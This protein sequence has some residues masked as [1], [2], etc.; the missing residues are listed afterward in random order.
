MNVENS[1]LLAV[2]R[3]LTI[4][5]KL[6]L[7]VTDED[8]SYIESRVEAEGLTFLTVSLPSLGKS[9]Y[10]SF[11]TGALGT[12]EGFKRVKGSPYPYFL[13]KAW[14]VLFDKEGNLR[15]H[16][17]NLDGIHNPVDSIHVE[18]R[19]RYSSA[20]A[21][22]SQLTLMFYKLKM[23]YSD[24][25]VKD[26]STSFIATEE[27]L[28][29]F[30]LEEAEQ[31]DFRL[32][33]VLTIARSIICRLLHRFDPMEISPAHGSGA[34]SCKMIPW[35]RYG[36][37]RYVPKLDA[38][39]DYGTWFYSGALGLV[40]NIDK[41]QASDVHQELSARVC[42]VPKDSRGPRLI[43]A[44]PREYMYIQQGL[45]AKLYQAIETYPMVRSM[46]SCI[47]QSRNRE[48]AQTGSLTGLFATIDLKD[49]SDRVSLELVR[50]L[51]PLN[52]MRCLEACRSSQTE[53][54][55]GRLVHLKKFAPMGSAC[56][57]PV[58]A[59]VFWAIS[60]AS[61]AVDNKTDPGLLGYALFQQ[62]KRDSSQFGELPNNLNQY[63]DGHIVSVFGDDIIAPT[64]NVVNIIQT[65]EDVGL[66]VNVAKCFTKGPF[67]E[68][69]GG[70][71]FLGNNISPIRWNY[72]PTV[73]GTTAV[74]NYAMFRA[75]DAMNNL[76]TR[77][78]TLEL[79]HPLAKLF[80]AWYGPIPLLTFGSRSRCGEVQAL[81]L[82]LLSDEDKIP[83]QC[84]V[85]KMSDAPNKPYYGNQRQIFLF[86][87]TAV[88]REIDNSDWCHVLR[89]L[90]DKGGLKGTSV[91]S[92]AKRL[93]YRHKWV[94]V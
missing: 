54:P 2:W 85:R 44:E 76:I 52:W 43:S 71:Y 11:E 93:K 75:C 78:G 19:E 66:K 64:G 74:L 53:L 31:E 29:T 39:Y 1:R 5:T 38:V 3:A 77:Y 14:E 59:L 81:G 69:C 88:D 90:L 56:C 36:A 23:P 86:C 50:R 41:L 47:D 35:A 37:P 84:R 80:N 45:M 42:F 60:L 7:Y 91:I 58:E 13:R 79:S 51:F 62:P 89:S 49:A 87:E 10:R 28:D 46:V 27:F 48:L 24:Q 65:L 73:N 82:S 67:R 18:A 16:L 6:S 70:D 21:C 94:N 55:D 12:C 72:I 33:N 26:V 57:F 4:D 30:S 63:P 40:D 34:S 83:P 32:S 17:D 92:L 61:V 20:A 25:Q 15:W 9:M 68:S 8:L 22:I